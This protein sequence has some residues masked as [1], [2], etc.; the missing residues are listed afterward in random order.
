MDGLFFLASVI[1]TGL[2]MLWVIQNDSA[3]VGESTS[4]L[5]AMR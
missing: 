3:G 2:I 5:F 1:A 4:G